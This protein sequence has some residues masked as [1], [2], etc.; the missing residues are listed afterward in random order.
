MGINQSGTRTVPRLDLGAAF[1]E[2]VDQQ[3]MLAGLQALPIFKSMKKAGTFNAITREC[4]T[5]D[6]ETKRAPRAGYNRE[7]AETVE[8]QF[9]CEEHGLEGILD[10]SERELYA[11]DFDAELVT[12]QQTGGLVLL[13]QEKRIAA[14][15]LNTT[16]FTGSALYTDNSGAPWDAAG[17]DAIGQVKLAREKVRQNT[18]LEPNALIMSKTN[19]DRLLLNTAVKAAIQY[20][21][22]LTEAELVNNLAEILGV[23]RLI[24]GKAIR[25]SAN[26]GKTF[27]GADVWNDDYAL[28]AVVASEGQNLA[29][30]SIGRTILWSEDS[31]E[32]SVVEQYRDDKVRSDIFRVRHT[33][34][35]LIIDPYFGHLMKVDA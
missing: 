31:P 35:E 3:T 10:D 26:K 8:V 24:V 25:N 20:V 19:L 18:G 33:V 5:K 1:M 12:T 16:T 23:K 6:V 11:S 22:K 4:L 2:F 15:L 27:V 21:A 7:G 14:A 13:S 30:P 29:Q 32:N 34:D 17:S 9:S 28:V